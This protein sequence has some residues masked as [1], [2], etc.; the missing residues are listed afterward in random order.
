VDDTSSSST[1]HISYT[2]YN[3]SEEVP[4]QY[5]SAATVETYPITIEM[6]K[7][8]IEDLQ[9]QTSITI[10][11]DEQNEL[12]NHSA[13]YSSLTTTSFAAF[14]FTRRPVFLRV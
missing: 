12:L 7:H 10:G 14:Y 3:D 1:I 5:S 9:D 4:L 11:N 2:E 13:E 8:I 6:P